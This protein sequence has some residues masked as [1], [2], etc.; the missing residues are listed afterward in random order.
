MQSAYF[1][2]MNRIIAVLLCSLIITTVNAQLLIEPVSFNLTPE[3]LVRTFFKSNGVEITKVEFKGDSQALARFTDFQKSTGFDS[4]IL[5]STGLAEHAAGPNARPNAG[6]NFGNHFFTDEDFKT[7]NNMCDGAVLIIDFVPQF[8]SLHF[9]FVFA[10]EEYPEFVQKEFNDV[11]AFYLTPLFIA[12]ARPKNIA[13]LPKGPIV[14]VNNVNHRINKDLYLPNNF[15]NSP[16]FAYL[17]YD[18]LTVPLTAQARVI[19]GKP[20]RMKILIADIGDC[21]YDSGVFLKAQSFSTSPRQRRKP[22]NKPMPLPTPVGVTYY[23]NF[24]SSS[25]TL[26]PT[27][28]TRFDQLAD[29]IKGL[30]YEKILI[31]G[32]TDAT[33]NES[34]NKQLSLERAGRVAMELSQRGIPRNKLKTSG[35]GSARPLAENSNKTGR[36][37]NRRVELLFYMR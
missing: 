26:S 13:R 1:R 5:I 33:G 29:S 19:P 14:S 10:S 36:A 25:S 24:E 21:E 7:R 27:E 31:L 6:A 28:Q 34:K 35:K 11:F 9:R 32:H 15:P 8:D 16:Q 3:Q 12:N 23:F 37:L 20:Y 2:N 4:G 22:A 30:N 18:G 17:E